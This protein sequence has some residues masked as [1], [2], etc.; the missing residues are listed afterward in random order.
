MTGQTLLVDGGGLLRRADLDA[1]DMSVFVR[2]EEIPARV[3]E[4]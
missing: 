1:D 3:R 4:A 2:D